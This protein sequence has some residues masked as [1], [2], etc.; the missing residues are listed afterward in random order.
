LS[1]ASTSQGENQGFLIATALFPLLIFASAAL[2]ALIAQKGKGSSEPILVVDLVGDF[3]PVVQASLLAMQPAE[4]LPLKQETA[5]TRDILALMTGLNRRVESGDIQGYIVVDHEAVTAEKELIY[6]AR[7]PSSIVL[8]ERL[9]VLM[10]NAVTRYRLAKAGVSDQQI[11]TAFLRVRFGVQKATND[12]ARR[13]TDTGALFMTFGLVLAMYASLTIYGVHVLR[14]VLEEK[15]SRIV[16]IIISSVSSTDLMLGKIFGIGAVGLTQVCIWSICSFL[17]TAPQL[18]SALSISPVRMPVVHSTTAIFLPV[19]FV[20]GYLL[21]STIFAAIGAM[22]SSEEDAQQMVVVAQLIV[23]TPVPLPARAIKPLQ[24]VG[25]NPIPH[26]LSRSHAHVFAHCHGNSTGL[27]DRAV[28]RSDCRDDPGD[29]V[30]YLEDL[31]SRHTHVREEA[32]LARTVELATIYVERVC[33]LSFVSAGLSAPMT[34][35]SPRTW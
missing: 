27:A 9:S 20:L 33:L 32:D 4:R 21:F 34:S 10:R 28:D 16:E 26:P 29:G 19:Y 22:F 31:P 25:D 6:F 18:V 14:G 5:D 13:E 23:A 1:G 7:N 24:C 11:A 15:S 35:W 2:P 3:Y 8:N 17:V 12:P 30:A